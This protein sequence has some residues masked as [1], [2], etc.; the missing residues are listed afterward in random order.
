[1]G[2]VSSNLSILCLQAGTAAAACL[3]D[4]NAV[5]AMYSAGSKGSVLNISQIVACVGQQNVEGQRVP[6]GFSERT[7]PHF[8]KGDFGASVG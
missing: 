7:L 5:V 4:R 1:M 2:P 8:A 6:R 3:D